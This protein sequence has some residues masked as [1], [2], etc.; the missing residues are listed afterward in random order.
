MASSGHR[1]TRIVTS[2]GTDSSFADTVV[3]TVVENSKPVADAG[4]DQ[5][6]DEGNL[7]KLDGA[8]SSDPDGGDAL[9]FQWT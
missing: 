6:K 3:I 8:G 5:T 1:T 7:V 2:F 9:S 4:P